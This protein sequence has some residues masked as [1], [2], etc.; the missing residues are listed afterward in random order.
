MMD[1]KPVPPSLKDQGYF[2]GRYLVASLLF[3]G[4]VFNYMLRVNINFAITAMVVSNPNAT[5]G[6]TPIVDDTCGFEDIEEDQDAYDGIFEWDEWTQGMITGSF[7]WG[8][9]ITQIPGGRLAEKVGGRLVYGGCMTFTALLTFLIPVAA[10]AGSGTLIAIRFM[11][12]LSEG[13]TFPA[14]STL[15][16]SWCP[17]IER[18]FFNTFTHIGAQFGIVLTYPLCAL[19]IQNLGWEFAFYIPAAMT[20]VWSVAWFV[21]VTN[22]PKD[23]RWV[24]ETER[25]YILASLG[26]TENTKTQAVPIRSILTSVPV[27]ALVITTFGDG[28]GF[29]TLLTELPQYMKI[30]LKKDMNSNAL[31]S[32]LPYLGFMAMGVCLS[33][34]G[35]ILRQRGVVSTTTFRKLATGLGQLGP[36][37]CLFILTWVKCDKAATSGLL[38][39]AVA[40]QVGK[41]K[42][43]LVKIRGICPRLWSKTSEILNFYDGDLEGDLAGHSLGPRLNMPLIFTLY[44]REVGRTSLIYS[45][46]NNIYL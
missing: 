24:S 29:Y 4:N 44:N 39:A 25:D 10:H 45:L 35:D 15:V 34:V 3:F 13:A 9:I 19:L 12:G 41:Y 17:P 8:Y 42:G 27:L 6:S 2:L 7:F 46:Y 18:S 5:N 38:I 21:F 40:M 22:S 28:W 26:N 1:N 32:A 30:M 37:V 23:H 20:L 14:L 36:A 11:L 33:I 43:H 31:S 16:A